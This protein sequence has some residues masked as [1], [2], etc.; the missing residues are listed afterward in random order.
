MQ[1]AAVLLYGVVKG[2]PFLI[3]LVVL[4]ILARR[5][6]HQTLGELLGA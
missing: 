5:R 4:V 2:L 6:E 3:G 1:G